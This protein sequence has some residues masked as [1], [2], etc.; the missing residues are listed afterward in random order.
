MHP[1]IMHSGWYSQ[2]A[3]LAPARDGA[4]LPNAAAGVILALSLNQLGNRSAALS[5][6][7]R[8]ESVIQTGFDL[9][10]DMWYWRDWV[11]VHLLLQEARGFIGQTAL[12]SI[13]R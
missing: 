11:L 6:S 13:Q 8:A 1:S 4:R 7:E 3:P 2:D 12:P 5:E 10:D 9:E